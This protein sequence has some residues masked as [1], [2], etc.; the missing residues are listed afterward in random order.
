MIRPYS[1]DSETIGQL[2]QL[3]VANYGR[4]DDLYVAAEQ[5][6]DQDLAAICRKLADD[7]AANTAHLE[8]IIVM[9]GKEPGFREAA[10]SAMGHELMSLL[11]KGRGD[12]ML[13]S[14]VEREQSELRGQYDETIAATHDAD[15]RSLLEEQK[16]DVEFAEQVLRRISG[17]D[18]QEST[19]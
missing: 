16:K 14:A 9:H 11:R 18:A 7:L 15:A 3:V 4:R 10:A 13:V 8:Q 1:L 6:G 5:L 19:P 17:R 12:Q 2:R